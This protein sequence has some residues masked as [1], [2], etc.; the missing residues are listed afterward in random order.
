MRAAVALP[1]VR[2]LPLRETHRGGCSSGVRRAARGAGS[3][4]VGGRAG[5]ARAAAPGGRRRSV[6]GFQPSASDVGARGAPPGAGRPAPRRG[7]AGPALRSAPHSGQRPR[8]SGRQSGAI[9]A[10]SWIASR[11]SVSRSSSWW[12]ERRGASGSA[13]RVERLARTPMSRLGRTSSSTVD[14]ERH[15]RPARGSGRRCPRGSS[16]RRPL[17]RRP[18]FVRATRTPPS[19]G[20][21]L[22]ELVAEV[23]R[24]RRRTRGRGRRPAARRA[25]RR[26]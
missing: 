17:T 10:A 5:A 1:G 14:L 15:A 3:A 23:D 12:S 18:R 13:V 16:G 9:G 21:C 22:D 11:T 25:A 4:A 6:A 8:Q 20:R 2:D 7:R 26:R 24:G 19:S